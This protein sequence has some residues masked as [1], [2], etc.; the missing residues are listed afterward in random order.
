MAQGEALD[1]TGRL[2]IFW[3]PPNGTSPPGGLSLKKSITVS[4]IAAVAAGNALEFYDFTTF[5]FFAIQ[6]GQSFFPSSDDS[7]KLLLSLAT[8]GVGF[9]T[10]PLG[11]VVIGNLGDRWG[12]KPAMLLCFG[13]MGLAIL[14][15][16]LTP[17]YSRIGIAA[18]FLVVGFRLL[19]G[20]ALGG[21][22][23][24]ATAFLME[25]APVERR[26]LYVSM[27]FATQNLSIMAAGMVGLIL[28]NAM[29]A[30]QLS[31]WG[32]RIAMLLG[33]LVV[34]LGFFLLNRLPETFHLDHAAPRT[35]ITRV[36]LRVA[37][38]GIFMLACGTISTYTM[39]YLVTYG[40][41]TLGLPPRQA[42]GATVT[43]G[44]LGMLCNPI[45]GVASDR[46]G[47]KPVMLVAVA[48]LLLAALPCFIAMTVFKTPLSLYAG[49]AVMAAFV[50]ISL[51]PML[52]AVS[53]SLPQSLRSGGIGT[54]Y[55]LSITIFGG[56]AQFVVTWLIGV[57][58]TPLAP[59]FYL[60]AATILGLAAIIL[61]H[62]TAPAIAHSSEP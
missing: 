50:G 47:R 7:G 18:P 54:V 22:V 14:G 27:Q 36:H 6:I 12:R 61:M 49:G 21:E 2:C 52:I 10:R 9:L 53:E 62:E 60:S 40:T 37:V 41:H 23:G 1:A 57:L 59:G 3:I 46:F 34:P 24:P 38:L 26:G 20:F 48:L 4:Q 19:Q 16:A 32:W 51:P 5:A 8:F 39:N 45:G 35:K 15:L 28:S 17:S 29:S 55:A 42:F 44:L 13:L 43:T 31:D 11:G 33:T 30:Q 56:S 25:A 58:H